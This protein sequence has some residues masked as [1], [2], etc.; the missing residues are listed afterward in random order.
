MDMATGGRDRRA[1][2]IMVEVWEWEA[3]AMVAARAAPA[4]EFPKQ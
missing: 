1:A 2:K 4:G 3:V